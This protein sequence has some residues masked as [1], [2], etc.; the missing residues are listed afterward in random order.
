M[1]SRIFFRVILV[2]CI[3]SCEDDFIQCQKAGETVKNISGHLRI[4]S[5]FL[6]YINHAYALINKKGEKILI[7]DD[8]II[9]A[10]VGDSMYKELGK[11]EYV[12]I[13]KDSTYIQKWDCKQM[14]AIIVDKWMNK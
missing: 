6:D 14:K 8:F 1:L 7:Y 2:I 3:A 5:I 9:Q 10:K 4:D 13:K 12:L 11:T